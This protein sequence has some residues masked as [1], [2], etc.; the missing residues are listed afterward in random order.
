MNAQ[1]AERKKKTETKIVCRHFLLGVSECV[2]ECLRSDHF[3]STLADFLHLL[4]PTFRFHFPLFSSFSLQFNE[5]HNC[6]LI[7]IFF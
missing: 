6:R 1:T 7:I 5:I 4:L 3:L 2:C